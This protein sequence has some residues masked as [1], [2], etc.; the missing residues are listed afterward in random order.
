MGKTE[1]QTT[2]KTAAAANQKL[3][4]RS[5]VPPPSTAKPPCSGT[6]IRS[7][8]SGRWTRGIWSRRRWKRLLKRAFLFCPPFPLSPFLP[9]CHLLFLLFGF[10]THLFSL[11]LLSGNIAEISYFV[12]SSLIHSMPPYFSSQAAERKKAGAVPLQ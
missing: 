10:P 3:A 1:T 4:N 2:T 11:F 5:S 7:S 12:S 9:S 6:R 8:S